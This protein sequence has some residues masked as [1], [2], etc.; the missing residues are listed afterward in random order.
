MSYALRTDK[1]AVQDGTGSRCRLNGAT[2]RFDMNSGSQIVVMTTNSH[3]KIPGA[4]VVDQEWADCKVTVTKQGYKQMSVSC[5][6]TWAD[7][8]GHLGVTAIHAIAK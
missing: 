4:H 6:V 2:A 3:G 8:Q 7:E 5:K 1:L